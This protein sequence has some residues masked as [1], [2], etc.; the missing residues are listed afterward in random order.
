LPNRPRFLPPPDQ[1]AP[2]ARHSSGFAFPGPADRLTINGMT[3]SGKTTFAMWLFAESADF[4]KKPW[5]FVDYKNEQLLRQVTAE[6]MGE[7]IGLGETLPK[8]PGV[9]VVRPD[10]MKGPA[11]VVEFLWRVYKRGKI[12][13]F[14]DEATMIPELRGEGNSGGPFQ[15]LLSQGRS[16]E[17]PIWTLAQRPV[18][19]NKMVY[20]ES[21]FSC[22]F[23]LK[24]RKDLEKIIE[25]A[26][27]EHSENFEEVWSPTLRLRPH[28][29][30]WYDANQEKSWI[31][32]AAPPPQTILN[33]LFERVDKLRQH[34]SI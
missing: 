28:Y 21:N 34:R 8:N 13:L 4:D 12:G 19:V 10:V 26:I 14:L 18:H 15:S 11:P 29:S 17:I 22:A 20:S 5:V 33:I 16:K 7:E 31:L 6:E 32:R 25:E 3:G 30:R 2:V 1:S 23:K 27:P 24:S 9:Y